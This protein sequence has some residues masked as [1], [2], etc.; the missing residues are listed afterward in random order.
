[1]ANRRMFSLTIINSDPFLAL[2]IS[3]QALYF[4]LGMHTD[5]RGYISN[6]RSIIKMIGASQGDLEVLV[7]KKFILIRSDYLILQKHFNLNN[8]IQK[9]RFHETQFTED[10]KA[11]FFDENKSYTEQETIT[12][13]TKCIQAVYKLDT[14]VSLGQ[15]SLGKVS[16]SKVSI[17]DQKTGQIAKFIETLCSIDYT[18]EQDDDFEKYKNEFFTLL[19]E[20]NEEQIE[21]ALLK[22][23]MSLAT[24]DT[25]NIKNKI[26][27]FKTS[28]KNNLSKKC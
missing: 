27:Y 28:M 2:P 5:D 3:A 13:C 8:Y 10:L 15:S 19:N 12:P 7:Q 17:K 18:N 1:M 23:H 16:L 6:G 24:V 26:E 25:K 20:N 21:N 4:H 14:E 22:F 9:D 11:L